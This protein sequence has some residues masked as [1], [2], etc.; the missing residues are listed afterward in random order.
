MD[1][2]SSKAK[3][4]IIGSIVGII[5]IILI[6]TC[7]IYCISTS[8]SPKQAFQTVFKQNDELIL[9]YWESEKSP[10]LSAY[11]FDSDGTYNTYLST[12]I[13][14]GRYEIEGNKIYL[15][16]PSTGKDI[17]YKMTVSETK[18]TL[19]TVEE[20]GKES[21]TNEVLVYNRVEELNQKTLTDLIG[22]YVED[23]ASTAEGN[24][25]NN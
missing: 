3:F 22:E 4:K 18:L 21:E 8:Q 6:A 20:D 17:V 2:N 16:N 19:K 14:P 11:K 1:E 5:V 12:V 10:G 9:G 25:E 13:I 23:N 15:S 7:G 24:T